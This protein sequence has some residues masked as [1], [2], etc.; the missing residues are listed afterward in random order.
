MS[1]W[2]KYIFPGSISFRYLSSITDESESSSL[3]FR[4]RKLFNSRSADDCALYWAKV[5][6]RSSKTPSLGDCTDVKSD[7]S[8]SR[9]LPPIKITGISVIKYFLIPQLFHNFQKLY[10]K[11][12][13]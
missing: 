6:F 7:K 2:V 9:I 1:S 12:Q 11:N 4:K 5:G 10:I 8:V 13:G 3:I